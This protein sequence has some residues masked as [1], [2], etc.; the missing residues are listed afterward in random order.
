[1]VAELLDLV[2]QSLPEAQENTRVKRIQ[3][4]AFESLKEANRILQIDFA[5]A[6]SCGYQD[7]TSQH[8]IAVLV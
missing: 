3:S 6:Y 2:L 4:N 5:T 1:V 7:E 8:L